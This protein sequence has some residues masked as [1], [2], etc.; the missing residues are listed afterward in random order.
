MFLANLAKISVLPTELPGHVRS[1]M[2]A[3]MQLSQRQGTLSAQ[4]TGSTSAQNTGI[5]RPAVHSTG[6]P[7]SAQHTGNSNNSAYQQQNSGMNYLNQ[8]VSGSGLMYQQP[9]QQMTNIGF[10]SNSMHS[11]YNSK[12]Q[13]SQQMIASGYSNNSQQINNIAQINSQQL[14]NSGFNMNNE[15]FNFQHTGLQ[16]TGYLQPQATGSQKS[17]NSQNSSPMS[18]TTRLP[19]VQWAISPAEQSQYN[20]LFKQYDPDNTGFID[21]IS[22][23]NEVNA[24]KPSLL[25][26]VCVKEC[27][28]IY[29]TYQTFNSEENSIRKNLLLQCI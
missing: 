15:Q 1:Q 26:L 10:N 12:A 23:L 21:G 6:Q 25:N 11:V 13:Q 18:N 2:M 14:A 29:G 22:N 4:N 8:S 9:T 5:Q 27:S 24:P 16:N 19:Q 17:Y 3:A 28:H 7:I 20:V